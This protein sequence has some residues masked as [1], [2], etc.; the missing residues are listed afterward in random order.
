MMASMETAV[1]R[2]R[3]ERLVAVLRRV[4]EPDSVVDQLVSGGVR[5]VELTLDSDDALGAIERLRARGDVTVL[6][7][8]VRTAADAEGAIAAGAEACVAPGLVTEMVEACDRLGVP[9]IPGTLTP[10]EVEAANALGV[11]LVKLFP[12]GPFG[13]AYVRDLLAPMDGVQLLVTGGVDPSNAAAFLEGGAVAVGVGSALAGAPDV[14]A[15]ARRLVA[16]VRERPAR[17]P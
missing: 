1:D 8:T 9:A 3:S 11:E 16:A 4:R 7:G 17:R 15:E 2:I 10:T 14:E 12:A 5:V 13:P 6:A